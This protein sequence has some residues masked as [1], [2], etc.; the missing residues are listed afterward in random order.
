MGGQRQMTTPAQK[1]GA[2]EAVLN[3]AAWL[4]GFL[5]LP[6]LVAVPL[7]VFLPSPWGGWVTAVLMTGF[8]LC[9]AWEALT[10]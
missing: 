1:R 2:L 4:T 9:A 7:L 3:A 5:L 8:L 6:A 10:A